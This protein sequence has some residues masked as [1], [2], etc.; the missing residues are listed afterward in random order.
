MIKSHFSYTSVRTGFGSAGAAS[1][2][3]WQANSARVTSAITTAATGSSTLSP[4]DGAQQDK[5]SG[6]TTLAAQAAIARVKA[7]AAAKSKEIT[8]RIDA[9]QKSLTDAKSTGNG[10]MIV[11]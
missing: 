11:G 5:I 2:Q 3:R 9:A 6:L 10:P 8:D 7:D 4:F 1:Y